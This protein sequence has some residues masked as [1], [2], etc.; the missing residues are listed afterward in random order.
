M[1]TMRAEPRNRS[2]EPRRIENVVPHREAASSV[3]QAAAM[4]HTQHD[5]VRIAHRTGSER[6]PR[7]SLAFGF[8]VQRSS[9]N[10]VAIVIHTEKKNDADRCKRDDG[11]A[12]ADECRRNR[13][14]A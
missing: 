5:A 12:S 10:G 3:P 6:D 7:L 11:S 14:D 2:I 4:H 9:S 8:L 1:G 13:S